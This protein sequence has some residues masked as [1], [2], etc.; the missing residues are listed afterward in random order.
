[1]ANFRPL[2]IGSIGSPEELTGGDTYLMDAILVAA[3]GELTMGA[4]ADLILAQGAVIG[5]SANNVGISL[6]ASSYITLGASGVYTMGADADFNLGAKADLDIGTTS[7]IDIGA[8]SSFIM[9]TAGVFNLGTSTDFDIGIK[10]TIDIGASGAIVVGANS[11]V[12]LG[13]NVINGVSTPLVDTDA[14]NK[15]YVDNLVVGL[16]WKDPVK[17]LKMVSDNDQSGSAPVGAVSGDAYVVNNWGGTYVDGNIMELTSGTTWAIVVTQVGSEP[18]TGTRIIVDASP[19]AASSFA[20]EGTKIGVYNASLDSWV[21]TSVI[22][23]WALIVDGDNSIYENNG[24]TYD[25]DTSSWVLFSGS[26]IITAG[27]GIVKTGQVIS[28]DAG[29]GISVDSVGIHVD[30]VADFGISVDTSG[31]SIKAESGITLSSRGIGVA[32]ADG[33]VVDGDGVN[34]NYGNGLTLDGSN[35]I[36]VQPVADFGISVDTSGVSVKLNSGWGLSVTTD[37]LA[38][39]VGDGIILSESKLQ[40]DAVADFGLSVDASGVSIKKYWGISLDAD[41]ISVK[42]GTG[43]SVDDG[44]VH[45]SNANELVMTSDGIITDGNAVCISD[46]NGRVVRATCS[47]DNG[48]KVVGISK[49]TVGTSGLAVDVALAGEVTITASGASPTIRDNVYLSTGGSMTITPPTASGHHVFLVGYALN[50]SKGIM[51]RFQEMGKRA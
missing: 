22:N 29:S 30:A 37:G 27:D 43:I 45:V 31:V 18:P 32:G 24:Y 44:G 34:V 21:F 42:A 8:S 17:V 4:S 2:V 13:S 51:M 35:Y 20:G 25:G 28:A 6:G 19:S 7:T 50:A 14:A 1:M 16:S 36:V 46:V 9:G 3:N 40:V 48:S 15:V 23:G 49:T 41:G 38:V 10:S 11:I 47:T 33:I 5:A 39:V 26:G 12:N